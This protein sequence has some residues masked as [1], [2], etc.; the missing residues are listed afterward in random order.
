MAFLFVG[1]V[2]AE[3]KDI[4]QDRAEI[5]KATSAGERKEAR[6][7]LREDIQKRRD[8]MKKDIEAKRM[9]FK[10]KVVK[11]KDEKKKLIVEKLDAR[12]NEINAKRTAQMTKH[13]DKMSEILAK[14]T[15]DTASASS[16][17]QTARDAVTAQAAKTYVITI[18]TEANLKM[19][20]GKVRSQLEADLKSVNEL[21]IA[22][23]KAV[24][25]L[26]K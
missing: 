17:I 26:L 4:R 19:D 6:T 14:V 16:A 5:R 25:S 1:T 23:R 20:V 12:F 7:E 8:V 3:F 9:E 22:A 21:V 15:G 13:L 11:I 24:Q 18:S 10:T 2:H